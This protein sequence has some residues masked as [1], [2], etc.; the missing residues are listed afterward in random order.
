MQLP[1]SKD[2]HFLGIW[3]EPVLFENE[4]KVTVSGATKL[5]IALAAIAGG[6]V[7]I[8]AAAVVYLR[9]QVDARSVE[10]PILARGWRYD[11]TVTAFMGGPGRRFFELVAWFDKT[12]IDGVVTGTGRVTETVGTRLRAT[13]TGLVRNYALTVVLGTVVLVTYFVTR[14]SF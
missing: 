9:R 12:I 14:T 1:F 3:L 7:G 5:V 10:L 11:E 8:F 6:L 13:Q 2:V 4:V